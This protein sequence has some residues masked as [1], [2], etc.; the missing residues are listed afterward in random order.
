VPVTW[1]QNYETV[2][3]A[4]G[5]LAEVLAGT[6][7]ELAVGKSVRASISRHDDSIEG[8]SESATGDYGVLGNVFV[9][10]RSPHHEISAIWNDPRLE[11]FLNLTLSNSSNDHLSLI[12]SATDGPLLRAFVERLEQ[13]LGLT[14]IKPAPERSKPAAEI[15]RATPSAREGMLEPTSP[16]MRIDTELQKVDREGV[17]KVVAAIVSGLFII[18]AA[19]IALKK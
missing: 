10:G 18:A 2:A 5:Q 15:A 13:R 11:F 3:L 6:V 4:P 12:V 1:S 7:S 17:W 14:R 19:W 16:E 9:L 8:L